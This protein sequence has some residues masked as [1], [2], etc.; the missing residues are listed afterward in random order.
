ME[1]KAK[2]NP[3]AYDR[4]NGKIGIKVISKPSDKPSKKDGKK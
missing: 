2:D 4:W 1:K 3:K